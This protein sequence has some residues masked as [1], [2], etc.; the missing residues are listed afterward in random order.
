MDLSCSSG[1][2]VKG[3]TVAEIRDDVIIED[4]FRLFF[5]GQY[6]TTLVASPDRLEDLGAGFIICEG[7]SDEIESVS[8]TGNDISVSAVPRKDISLELESSGGFRVMGEAKTVDSSIEI[9]PDGVRA[10]TGAIES[11]TWRRTGGVHCSVLFCEGDLVTR[12]CDVGRHNT[13]DKVVGYAARGGLDR[14]QCVVGCT[15]RQPAGMVAKVANAGI[16]IIISRAA[17]TNRGIRAADRAGITLICFSRGDRFTIYTHPE[18]VPDV[19]E[20]MRQGVP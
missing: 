1:I 3:D 9:T 2:Q 12:A 20:R 17:S 7:L 8:V 15:G 4:H 11:E 13:L 6:L 16:P 10:V 19:L 18:R 5:N 14:S